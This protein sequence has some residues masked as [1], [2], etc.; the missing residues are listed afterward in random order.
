MRTY[1]SPEA[2][3]RV[4]GKSLTGAAANGII[5]LINSGAATLD[6]SGRQKAR[7]PV[8]AQTVLGDHPKKWGLPGC[9]PLVPGQSVNISAVAAIR[10]NLSTIGEMPVTMMRLNLVK[11][12]GPVLQLAEGYTVELPTEVHEPLN[13]RTDPTWPTTWFAPDLTGPGCFPRRLF[14]DE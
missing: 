5:H 11:G 10:R 6:G 9:D 12:I 7:G 8:R 4:T 3:K 1:W 13:Q 14:R 2:V